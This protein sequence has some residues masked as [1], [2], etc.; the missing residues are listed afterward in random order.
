MLT[1]LG[2]MNIDIVYEDFTVQ[3]QILLIFVNDSPHV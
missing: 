2:R 3:I 1:K